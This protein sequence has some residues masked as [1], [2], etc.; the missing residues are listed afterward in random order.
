MDQ[1]SVNL[2]SSVQE[3]EFAHLLNGNSFST[4]SLPG[5]RFVSSVSGSLRYL[6]CTR[7]FIDCVVS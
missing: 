7:G 5:V 2:T 3:E 1:T 6:V 4:T